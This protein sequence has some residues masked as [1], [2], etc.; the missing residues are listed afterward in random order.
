[1]PTLTQVINRS[2]NGEIKSGICIVPWRNDQIHHPSVL[3]KGLPLR[4]PKD[5]KTESPNPPTYPQGDLFAQKDM[6]EFDEE[7]ICFIASIGV[8]SGMQSGGQPLV[9]TFT[10]SKVISYLF[11]TGPGHFSKSLPSEKKKTEKEQKKH[12]IHDRK[13]FYCPITPKI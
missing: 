12:L 1:L 7:A 3:D 8:P 5:G 11:P 6:G 13:P 2:S 9:I 4:T 10:A